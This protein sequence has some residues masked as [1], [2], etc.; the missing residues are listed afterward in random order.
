MSAE[1]VYSD[2]VRMTVTARA[3]FDAQAQNGAR[4][5]HVNVYLRYAYVFG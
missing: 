1:R 3:H 4:T 5:T 2:L